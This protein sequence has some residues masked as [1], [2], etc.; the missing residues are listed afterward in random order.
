MP[1][2]LLG[3]VH[4]HVAALL[5][6]H[7]QG[8][9]EWSSIALGLVESGRDRLDG[10]ESGCWARF[11]Y[12]CRRSGKKESSAVVRV[13][14]SASG[15]D[16]D[17]ISLLTLRNAVSIDMPDLTQMRRRSRAS[18][19]ALVMDALRFEITLDRKTSGA[20]TPA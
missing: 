9:P 7:A 19:H 17:P 16:C 11:S 14:S 18:G 3:L 13:S 6:K 10:W 20:F 1:Q 15:T 4:A 2:P 8:L 12:A 5:G